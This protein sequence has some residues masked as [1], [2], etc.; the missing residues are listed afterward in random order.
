MTNTNLLYRR[1]LCC[2][3]VSVKVQL[4]EWLQLLIGEGVATMLQ[5]FLTKLQLLS[6]A[7]GPYVQQLFILPILFFPIPTSQS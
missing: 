1:K 4:C 2:L 6:L 5:K 7:R 3:A